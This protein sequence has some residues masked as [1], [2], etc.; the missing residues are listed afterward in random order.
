MTAEKI[1]ADQIDTDE[2]MVR[3]LLAD[4]F[5]HWADLPVRAAC[6]SRPEMR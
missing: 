6:R 3:R 4:Q 1:H 5:P 2:V